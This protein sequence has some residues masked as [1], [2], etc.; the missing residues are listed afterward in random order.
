MDKKLPRVF[1]N[2]QEKKFNNNKKIY[3]SKDEQN[4]GGSDKEN[5][6][7]AYLTSN[8]ISKNIYQK[9]NDIFN[10]EKYVYKADVDITTKQGVLKTK[11][12]GQNRTHII[13]MDNE[14]IAISEI[15]DINFSE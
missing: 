5:K 13:T 9:L 4:D 15:D 3:Y 10:S 7:M 8:E 14:L 2:P 1:A 11:I 12:I 6:R